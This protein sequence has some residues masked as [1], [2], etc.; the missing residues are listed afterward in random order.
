M[1]LV[2]FFCVNGSLVVNVG[3]FLLYE[4]LNPTGVSYDFDII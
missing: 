2:I 1:W 4:N 3:V